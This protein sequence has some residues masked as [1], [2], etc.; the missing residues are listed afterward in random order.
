MLSGRRWSG[1]TDILLENGFLSEG[2]LGVFTGGGG[3]DD[4]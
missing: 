1:S 4:A 3:L 2:G